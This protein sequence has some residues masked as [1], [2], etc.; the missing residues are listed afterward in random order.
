MHH[1]IEFGHI[2]A[3]LLRLA[4]RLRH[5]AAAAAAAVVDDPKIPAASPTKRGPI[6]GGPV[7]VRRPRLDQTAVVGGGRLCGV[8]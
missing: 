7:N 6:N 2:K 1:W 4:L 8:G 5:A 3:V